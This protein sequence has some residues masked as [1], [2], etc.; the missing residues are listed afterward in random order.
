MSKAPPYGGGAFD[1]LGYLVRQELM[2]GGFALFR[3]F[4]S[5]ITVETQKCSPKSI[6]IWRSKCFAYN[7]NISK[8]PP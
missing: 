6:M 1:H 8:E 3:G 4:M 5:G 7:M 2:K